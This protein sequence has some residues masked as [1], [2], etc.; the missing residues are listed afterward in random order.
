M[1]GNKLVVFGHESKACNQASKLLSWKE[2]FGGG[3]LFKK[4]LLPFSRLTS[5]GQQKPKAVTT[6]ICKSFF[7]AALFTTVSRETSLAGAFNL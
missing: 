7:L 3:R 4:L 2:P 1:F 6:T 5:D